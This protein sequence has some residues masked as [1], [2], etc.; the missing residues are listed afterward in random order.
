M[1]PAA[2]PS[3]GTLLYVAV[4]PVLRESRAGSVTLA[5]RARAESCREQLCFQG[6]LGRR[7]RAEGSPTWDQPTR[8]VLCQGLHRVESSPCP[9]SAARCSLLALLL[10]SSLLSLYFHGRRML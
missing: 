9:V 6:S 7:S 1:R 10:L 5:G 3:K 8:Q 2:A 4:P